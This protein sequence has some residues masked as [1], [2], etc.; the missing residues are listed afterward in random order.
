MKWY[1]WLVHFVNPP[2]S[3]CALKI[4]CPAYFHL[5]TVEDCDSTASEVLVVT[6]CLPGGQRYI[7]VLEEQDLHLKKSEYFSEFQILHL[8]LEL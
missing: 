2:A 4:S 7:T 5:A 1:K 3:R 6:V 8:T